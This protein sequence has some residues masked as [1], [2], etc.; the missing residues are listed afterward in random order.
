M[1]LLF[2]ALLFV[3]CVLLPSL[4]RVLEGIENPSTSKQIAYSTQIMDE[5][6]KYTEEKILG[7][8][9]IKIGRAHV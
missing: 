3:I 7:P 8:M 6:E 5:A 9:D 2:L 1:R 4:F